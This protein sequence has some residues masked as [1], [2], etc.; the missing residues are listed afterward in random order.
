MASTVRLIY[1]ANIVLNF[2]RNCNV[3]YNLNLKFLSQIKKKLPCAIILLHV[4][5]I[6]NTE[7]CMITLSCQIL[8]LI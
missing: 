3:Q 7:L 2:I 5:I 8:L 6:C 4:Y 1:I